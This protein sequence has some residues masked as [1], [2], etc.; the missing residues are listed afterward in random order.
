VGELPDFPIVVLEATSPELV[1]KPGLFDFYMN[2]GSSGIVFVAA[3]PGLLREW[4]AEFASYAIDAAFRRAGSTLA[5]WGIISGDTFGFL[6]QAAKLS[7]ADLSA[8]YGVPEV[9]IQAWINNQTPVD[10]AVWQCLAYL[11]C[12][13]DGR[14]FLPNPPAPVPAPSLRPR[15]IRVFPNV[16]TPSMPQSTTPACPPP[17]PRPS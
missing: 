12:S 13:L 10:P 8:R 16:P 6:A 14:N 17:P 5:Q 2:V 1:G 3:L 4:G 11:V 9:T 15:Q 7:V